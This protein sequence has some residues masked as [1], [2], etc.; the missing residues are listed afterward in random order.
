VAEPEVHDTVAH[1]V[2]AQHVGCA[3]C[4]LDGK[5]AR[6]VL[7]S[8]HR[9]RQPP[10]GSEEPALAWE[11][12]RYILDVSEAVLQDMGRTEVA[13]LICRGMLCTMIITYVSVYPKERSSWPLWGQLTW[14]RRR[15][16]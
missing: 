2:W 8:R 13:S 10:Q 12:V 16:R 14:L 5:G 6:R 15:S 9:G 1:R 7:E 4:D 3:R 11:G